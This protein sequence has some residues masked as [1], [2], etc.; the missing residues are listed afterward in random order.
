MKRW[1]EI[2]SYIMGK[3]VEFDF[4]Q[5]ENND[6]IERQAKMF[7]DNGY[8]TIVVI[9]GDGALQDAVNGIMS[10]DNSAQVAMG[11]IPNG[12][13]NDFTR[14]WGMSPHDYKAAVD[15]IIARRI[16]KVDLGCCSYDEG[17]QK[18]F[19]MNV[20]NIGLSAHIVELANRRNAVF[21]KFIY[22]LRAVFYLLFKRQ[23]FHMRLKLNSQVVDKK[24]MILSVGNSLGYGMT[25]SAVPYNGWLDVSAI[26]MPQFFGVIQG[27]L[28]VMRRKILNFGLV[29]P[30]RTT[31]MVI[32]SVGGAPMGI[33][34]RPF[35]PEFPMHVT[36]E[37][38]ILNLII[39]TNIKNRKS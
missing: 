10:S 11:I 25:P 4:I 3:G 9:G 39:P 34:G 27:T 20:L 13:A 28:M 22:R 12:I 1:K 15:C 8:G 6:S 29:E 26:K 23:N 24:F 18:R 19:F 5:S 33:D 38:E 21:A 35:K 7:A 36:V 32:E 17:K 16:R 30:F 37:P 14:F 31:E 2:R